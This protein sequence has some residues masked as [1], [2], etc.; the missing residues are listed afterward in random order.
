[1]STQ[2]ATAT[3]SVN[4]VKVPGAYRPVVLDEGATVADAL[5]ALDIDPAG[6]AIRVGADEGNPSTVLTEGSTVILTR[7]VKGN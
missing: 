4:V 1:M 3:V 5:S 2:T 7:Q 6:Y